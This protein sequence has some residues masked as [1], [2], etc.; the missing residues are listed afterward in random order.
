[1]MKLAIKALCSVEMS[2]WNKVLAS[3]EETYFQHAVA[4]SS[5]QPDDFVRIVFKQTFLA[6]MLEFSV[7][8]SLVTEIPLNDLENFNC[9]TTSIEI[10]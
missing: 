5:F 10:G 9:S 7:F 6:G 3:V 2:V 4:L 8:K 1:M